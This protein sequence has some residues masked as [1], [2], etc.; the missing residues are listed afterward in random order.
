MPDCKE[1][2]RHLA[3]RLHLRREPSPYIER[4]REIADLHEF[5]V[6][7]YRMRMRREH[8]EAT[9]MDLDAMVRA[10]MAEPPRDTY[11]HRLRDREK[12]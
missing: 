3:T 7:A 2:L 9:D 12:K 5:G 4:M 8:P 6:N 10:W 11:L 1:R